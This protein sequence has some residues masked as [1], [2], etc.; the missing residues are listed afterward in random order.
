MS[1]SAHDDRQRATEFLK[2]LDS[3]LPLRLTERTRL[4]V[5]IR[6]EPDG[7]AA[8]ILKGLEIN[9]RG[10]ARFVASQTGSSDSSDILWWVN[11]QLSDD[12]SRDNETARAFYRIR[13]IV[14]N[15]LLQVEG[16]GKRWEGMEDARRITRPFV[17]SWC[18]SR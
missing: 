13:H 11:G 15:A 18:R 7:L 10:A 9:G 2:L 6:V 4:Q 3:W 16:G 14:D 1:E 12:F 5:Q 17:P 8:T